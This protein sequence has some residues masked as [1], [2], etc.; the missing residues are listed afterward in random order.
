[1]RKLYRSTFVA[2]AVAVTANI[3]ESRASVYNYSTS[4]A[5]DPAYVTAGGYLQ[6][7]TGTPLVLQ[8]G[9]QLT[10][11]IDFTNGSL[12]V[13]GNINWLNFN[14]FCAGGCSTAF[15]SNVTL[16]GV[17]GTLNASNPRSFGT[18]FGNAVIGADFGNVNSPTENF[19]FTGIAYT[20]DVT[21]LTNYS[22]QPISAPFRFSS[23]DIN[24]DSV[25]VNISS[26]VPEPSTWAMMILGFAGVGLLAY[27]RKSSMMLRIA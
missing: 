17:T 14:F 19:S 15:S 21:G 27:R 16:L 8:A 26:A 11:T 3:S 10:G 5:L 4:V 7:T 23:I 6:S 9:D 13:Q 20:I 1:M 24:A 2:A 18:A 12:F 22:N 25:S